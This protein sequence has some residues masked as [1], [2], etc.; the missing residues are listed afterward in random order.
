[1]TQQKFNKRLT[2]TLMQA[3]LVFQAYAFNQPKTLANR[4]K[5]ST[6]LL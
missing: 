3:T 1:M 2:L 4:L 5:P 6:A